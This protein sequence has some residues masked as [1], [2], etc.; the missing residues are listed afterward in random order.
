[1]TIIREETKEIHPKKEKMYDFGEY[2]D[3]SR[4]SLP[5]ECFT[6]KE[7]DIGW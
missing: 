3:P 1:M 2:L 7:K 4:F 5:G 6:T